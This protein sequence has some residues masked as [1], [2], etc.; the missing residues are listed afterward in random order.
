VPRE[1]G[2]RGQSRNRLA[3]RRDSAG[4]LLAYDRSCWSPSVRPGRMPHCPRGAPPNLWATILRHRATFSN[5]RE[6]RNVPR[7][8]SPVDVP[9]QPALPVR[10]ATTRKRPRKPRTANQLSYWRA[11]AGGVCG[12]VFGTGSSHQSECWPLN[13]EP[14]R[15]R[16]TMT[17]RLRRT[18]SLGERRPIKRWSLVLETVVILADPDVPISAFAAESAPR[19]TASAFRS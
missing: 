9:P 12:T 7:S 2:S 5:E 17:A 4:E 8:L 16:K 15:P 18:T 14:A 11:K 13:V 6:L 1:F 19:R 10:P 3:R